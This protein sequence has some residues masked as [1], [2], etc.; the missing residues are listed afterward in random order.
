MLGRVRRTTRTDVTLALI[1]AG[2]VY[3]AWALACSYAAQAA[4]MIAIRSFAVTA[5]PPIVQRLVDTFSVDSRL[6]ALPAMLG[7]V[8]MCLGLWLVIRASRQRRIISW[9]WL[10]ITCQ[11]LAAMGIAAWASR[12]SLTAM[13]A[14]NAQPTP[15]GSIEQGLPNYVLIGVLIWLGTLAWLVIDRVRFSRHGPALGDGIRTH[16]FRR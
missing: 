12:A 16:T 5:Q 13:A 11:A 14:F 3:L 15:G 4:E 6:S 1:L 8:W 7:P 9:A 2:V 10:V